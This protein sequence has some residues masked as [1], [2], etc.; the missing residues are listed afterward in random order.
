MISGARFA[1]FQVFGHLANM[2]SGR[3]A[4]GKESRQGQAAGVAES[5]TSCAHS[6]S[7]LEPGVVMDAATDDAGKAVAER[8]VV[9]VD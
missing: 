7:G 2:G 8:L 1:E 5:H 4:A 3:N 9:F 6:E